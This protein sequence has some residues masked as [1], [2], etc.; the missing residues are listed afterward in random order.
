MPNCSIIFLWSCC[1][2]QSKGA[3]AGLGASACVCPHMVR[4]R[5][6][7]KQAKPVATSTRG[8]F[9]I[10]NPSIPPSPRQVLRHTGNSRPALAVDM[11]AKVLD[12][13]LVQLPITQP[14]LNPDALLRLR[15]KHG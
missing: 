15:L 12:K 7:R 4:I 5:P 6:G 1:V 11:P 13:Q 8:S 9:C 2:V 3:P 10:R 14:N